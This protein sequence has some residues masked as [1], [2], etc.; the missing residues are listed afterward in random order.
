[1]IV[2]HNFCPLS[3]TNLNQVQASKHEYKQARSRFSS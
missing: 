2:H 3:L 1:M